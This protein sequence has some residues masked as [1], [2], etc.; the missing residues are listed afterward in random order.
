VLSGLSAGLS[1]GLSLI[2]QGEFHALIS[3]EAV[4][5]GRQ[6]LFTRTR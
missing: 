4:V 3:D 5:L 6:Q 2:V 1:M